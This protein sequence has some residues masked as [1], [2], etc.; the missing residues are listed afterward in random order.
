MHARGGSAVLRRDAFRAAMSVAEIHG[1]A[2]SIRGS[3][4][5]QGD[6]R[7]EA[8]SLSAGAPQT[9]AQLRAL[10][11]RLL[12]RAAREDRQC[13]R[14]R[15]R[16]APQA[17]G[18][19]RSS[20]AS[21]PAPRNLRRRRLTCIRPTKTDCERRPMRSCADRKEDHDSRRRSKPY[22]AR[23]RV[24]L[25]LLPRLLR[26]RETGFETI[27]VNCNPETVSTDYDTS[28]RLY[29]EPLTLED[30]LEIV[31]V[32]QKPQGVIVQFGG[33]TP[34]K[35]ARALGDAGVPII[36]TSR[37]HRCRGGSR[38]LQRPDRKA[39]AL[40]T[41]RSHATPPRRFDRHWGGSG[42][43]VQWPS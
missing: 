6:P 2:R 27:M 29:F 18:V 32:E 7:I 1:Y 22:R 4:A 42:T 11:R 9:A 19:N 25:L 31:H 30:V 36:G 24:R 23:H 12:R 13:H 41:L 14:R 8:R 35:L 5:N 38:A 3:S 37:F 15:V 34:L 16:D 21:T 17:L 28:D 33:Q 10:R 20:S 26:A 43:G 40:A 39:E